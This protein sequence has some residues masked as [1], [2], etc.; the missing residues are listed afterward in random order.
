MSVKQD[1]SF[2]LALNDASAT[3]EHVGGK[4]ASLARLAMAGLPVPPGFSITVEAY[5]A[6]VE[7]NG[8]Q[9][10]ILAAVSAIHTGDPAALDETSQRIR[11]LFT[12]GEMPTDLSNA[13]RQA[14]AQLGTGNLFVAVRSSA[15]AEDLPEMSFAGQQ[16]TY[17]NIYGTA[18]V[19]DAV[20]RCWA[21]LW[22]ARAIDYR[23]R[24]NIVSS[25]VGLAVIVQE[26][27]PAEAA[28]ILFTA[29]P[30]TG[31]RDQV[32][33][34]ASWGLGEAIVGG[35]VTPDTLVVN[36]AD[37]TIVS[38]VINEKSTMTVR[39]QD[40]THEEPV[41]EDLRTRAAL[42]PAQ[43]AQL[44]RIGVQIESLYTQPMD[45]EWALNES[46]FFIVQARPITTLRI[47]EPAMEE[48]N[49][50]LTGDYLWTCANLG[51]AV[52]DVMT[53]STWSLI[54][55]F[56]AKTLGPLFLV[57][58]HYHPIANIGGRFYMN[59]SLNFSITAKVGINRKRF[60]A[61]T[62]EVFG[63][64]PDDLEVPPV[65]LSS[66]RMLRTIVP[67]TIRLQKRVRANCKKLP[68][69]IAMAP[70]RCQ[71][72]RGQIQAAA[73][74]ED[75][76]KLWREGLEP[77]FYECCYM[78]E[79][80]AKQD[81]SAL[82]LARRKLR[83]LVGDA[84]ANTLLSGLSSSTNHLASLGPV[85]GLAQLARGEIDRET[86]ARQYGHRCSYEFEISRPRPAEDSDWIDRQLAGMREAQTDTTKMLAR[87]QKVRETAW[88]HFQQR[89]P[90]QVASMR[91]H[92]DR[93]TTAVRD[94]EAARS[95]VIRAFWALRAFVL[96]AG[97]LTGQQEAIFFFSIDEIL[98]LLRGEHI[99]LAP[100][101]ARREAYRRYS[102]LPAYPTLIRG[103]FDPFKWAADPQ[104][105]NDIFD[106][107]GYNRPIEERISGFP[108]AMGVVEGRA[109]VITTIDEG[110]QLQPGEIL[111]TT[112]TNIG[113]TPLFPRAS[114]IVTDVGAPLS[115]AAIVA[116]ELGIPAVV[117]C[118]N[119]TMRLHTGDR[120][121]VNGVQGIVEVLPARTD[122][123]QA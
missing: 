115:H 17:L 31:A 66:W 29:N 97:E 80:G 83:K 116:R 77:Y 15:T 24:H 26:L 56:M 93:A 112:V 2:I 120:V 67:E 4:G 5:H 40:G 21:S 78:L 41:P 74:A 49:D 18:R 94:R 22:T 33:L 59:L 57:G 99:S 48:W 84:D 45:V 72:L 20:K 69:F 54:Q 11:A 118:G 114:A 35:L 51:E 70:A 104:R 36:K 47:Q 73:S 71:V 88:E 50:S 27:I 98:A 110:D 30:L 122:A 89:H 81:G 102:A 105:R 123:A 62:E 8:L 28:G 46:R 53:P 1:A 90:R 79:A 34:N 63:R 91:R 12:Q 64:I 58:L 111:V 109:R 55:I 37:G 38:Q 3:L 7:E 42:T 85:L 14:Y 23:A 43:V 92:I 19:L 39:S 52:P 87:Q 76:L 68:A 106:A 32:M 121:R 13:I 103:H 108:G 9:E 107:N 61:L 82:I 44:T 6:F 117:G 101:P 16:D 113:W 60:S 75:L 65:R 25:D 95:E 10:Q 119:A 86:F 96:R 100:I